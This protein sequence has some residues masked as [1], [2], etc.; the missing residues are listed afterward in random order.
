V[1]TDSA[2]A[3]RWFDQGI[4]LLYGYN[5][6]EAIRSF[7][8]AAEID[9][10]CAMAWWGSAMP[11]VCTSTTRN[12][13]GAKPAGLRSGAKGGRC[14]GRETPSSGAG[15]G[16]PPALRNGRC[17]K[18]RTPLDQ[19]TPTRWRPL[20]P[21]PRRSRRGALFAESLMN[22]QP[23]DLWTGAGGAQGAH[24]GDRRR[25]GTT[26]AKAPKHPGANH[27]YIHAIEASPWPE[28]GIEAPSG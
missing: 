10:S 24:A 27:F 9:P 19:R 18:D 16:R 12:G 20:A 1:T 11:A 4:Q 15:P 28:K 23:W 21:V 6:D 17:P 22:L 26:L 8:K 13:R 2:E 7:E 25:A 14:P 3:Q 5:H